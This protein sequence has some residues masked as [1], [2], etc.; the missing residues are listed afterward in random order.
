MLTTY[1]LDWDDSIEYWDK[2][3]YSISREK[4]NKWRTVCFSYFPLISVYLMQL[5]WAKSFSD[6]LIDLTSVVRDTALPQFTK[7]Q[8][9]PSL[10]QDLLPL[11]RPFAGFG[12]VSAY[13]LF[14]KR[15]GPKCSS[16]KGFGESHC[17][18]ILK[19]RKLFLNY[20]ILMSSASVYEKSIPLRACILSTVQKKVTCN[21]ILSR[22]YCLF[23]K[24]TE[25]VSHSSRFLGAVLS[26]YR[27]HFLLLI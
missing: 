23:L 27:Y 15:L 9:V 3:T 13:L 5:N 17:E 26:Q 11:N 12:H 6:H 8:I 10:K 7:I 19:A 2:I 16:A 14:P 18:S 21:W 20:L 1:I 25:R 24:N 4:R 22:T